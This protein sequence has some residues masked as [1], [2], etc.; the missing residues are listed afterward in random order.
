MNSDLLIKELDKMIPNPRCELNY[1]KDYELLIATVLSAQCTDKRVNMVTKELFDKYDI[2]SLAS[3]N[4]RDI[5][6][7]VRPVGT[8][9]RKSEYIIEI[10]KKL[11]KDYN[12]KV[13]NDRNYLESL[14]GVGRKTC[15]VVLSNI[16]DVPAIAVDT[17]VERVSKR[18]GLAYKNDSVL[19]VE[20]KLMRKIPKDKWS[21]THHQLVLFGRYICKSV[22]PDC[23]SCSL[24]EYC[25]HYKKI[26]YF[27]FFLLYYL[28]FG[29]YLLKSLKIK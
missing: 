23:N 6:K 26:W 11:V 27:R 2:F 20:K 22:N 14:P 1:N 25:K 8:Y 9:T 10:A 12:G 16:Y 28:Q 29:W 17:H 7:I 24:K 18:L 13:P 15:N 5:M 19:K 3:A 4:I 21:R